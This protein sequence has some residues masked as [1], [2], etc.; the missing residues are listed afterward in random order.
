MHLKTELIRGMLNG[1]Q[2]A[3]EA[4]YLKRTNGEDNREPK[5]FNG[6]CFKCGKP[7]HMGRDCRS[8]QNNGNGN[9]RNRDKTCNKCGKKGHIA[10]Q[11]RV[12]R[13]KFQKSPGQ[14]KTDGQDNG[15]KK[16]DEKQ[17]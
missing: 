12:K 17:S 1:I 7:G 9:N 16:N 8:A 15:E 14:K 2:H 4:H 13:G 5:K 10:R 6:C 11:C 3:R